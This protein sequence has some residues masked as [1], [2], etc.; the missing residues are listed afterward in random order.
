MPLHPCFPNI[1]P[2]SWGRSENQSKESMLD[3]TFS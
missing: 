3:L 2:P 1:N